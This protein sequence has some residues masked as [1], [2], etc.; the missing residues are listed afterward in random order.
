M[1]TGGVGCVA[2]GGAGCVGAEKG[3]LGNTPPTIFAAEI[4]F[5]EAPWGL[6]VKVHVKLA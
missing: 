3:K 4:P 6:K 5:A 2:T 1:A